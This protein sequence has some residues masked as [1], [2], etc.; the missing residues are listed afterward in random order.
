[1]TWII[2]DIHGCYDELNELLSLLPTEDRLI[3]VGDYVDRGPHSNKVIERLTQESHRSVFLMGNHESMMLAYYHNPESAEARSWTYWANGGQQTLESYGFNLDT[4]YQDYPE[5]HRE[6]LEKLEIFH[7]DE[8]FI[9]VH[10]GLRIN[11]ERSLTRQNR[12]DLLWIRLDWI[13]N[14]HRWDGKR[15]FY[16]HTPAHYINGQQNL[17]LPIKGQRSI[18]IDTGCVYG[19]FLTAVN[20]KTDELV[21]V[22]ARTQYI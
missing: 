22:S 10:A 15:V 21:Q 1:M 4:P 16:G 8:E 13:R 6:F 2:G 12:E 7:E 19:G 3:F 9:V 5:S 14:E 17:C 18:G 20:V 11:G